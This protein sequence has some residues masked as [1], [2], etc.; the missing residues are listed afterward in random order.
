MTEAMPFGHDEVFT[1]KFVSF[2][3]SSITWREQRVWQF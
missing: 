3:I 2:V 1:L